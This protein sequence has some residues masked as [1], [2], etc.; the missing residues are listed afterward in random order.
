VDHKGQGK[1]TAQEDKHVETED[2]IRMNKKRSIIKL[3]AT[4]YIK[5][6]N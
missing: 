6:D 1:G 2:E 4:N 3:N 5:S